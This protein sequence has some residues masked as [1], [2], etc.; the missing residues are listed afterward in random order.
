MTREIEEL[1]RRATAILGDVSDADQ[2][3]HLIRTTVER[4]GRLDILIN[5]AGALA[6][7]DRRPVVE[8]DEAE[9]DRIQR[10][11]VK[12]TFLCSRADFL[13]P[14]MFFIQTRGHF[15]EPYYCTGPW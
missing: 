14:P 6:G 15:L 10:V 3:D 4:L 9:W 1:G 13:I 7:A 5:N 2:A 8:L 11:N 12:G